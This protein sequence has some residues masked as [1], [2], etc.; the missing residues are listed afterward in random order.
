MTKTKQAKPMKRKGWVVAAGTQAAR[1]EACVYFNQAIGA[2]IAYDH[3]ARDWVGNCSISKN[4]WVVHRATPEATAIRVEQVVADF[5][6][7]ALKGMDN[8]EFAC[9]QRRCKELEQARERQELFIQE[10]VRNVEAH[11][12]EVL[13][14]RDA[15]NASFKERG[16]LQ[17]LSSP[18]IGK[19]VEAWAAVR[20]ADNAARVEAE[21]AKA[22]AAE[23]AHQ[24][25]TEVA[26]AFLTRLAVLGGLGM[27][28]LLGIAWLK[29][30]DGQAFGV[31]A[32]T[33]FTVLF[34]SGIY[35][36]SLRA[37]DSH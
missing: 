36:T 11:G 23:A 19:A 1:P 31:L 4:N 5:M 29:V 17:V 27:V 8:T 32:S 24:R 34:G 16:C 18:A 28:S 20:Q 26:R 35:G 37:K 22:V 6:L 10:C 33:F 14:L 7:K 12:A 13:R 3:E 15:L 9:L 25:Q 30:L 21:K 2:E